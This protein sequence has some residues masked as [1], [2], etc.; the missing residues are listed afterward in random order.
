[1]SRPLPP[2]ADVCLLLEGT[3]P[4]VSGG[5][6]SWVRD[7]IRSLDH[8]SFSIVSIVP[9]GA[10]REPVYDIPANVVGRID[11]PLDRL[12]H[13]RGKIHRARL[14]PT[15]A[16]LEPVLRDFLIAEKS[17]TDSLGQFTQILDKVSR[18]AAGGE[19]DL[20]N[21]PEA[22][23]SLC[24]L[25]QDLAPDASFLDFFWSLRSLTT[26]L[27]A[28]ALAPLPLASVYHT[29]CTGYAGLLG[30]RAVAETERPLVLTEHGI[31]TNE[32]RMEL[33]V[34]DWLYDRPTDSLAIE[35]AGR[36]LRDL[37]TGAFAAYARACYEASSEIITL[38]SGNQDFQRRDGAREERL[39]V[40]PNGIDTERFS[41]LAQAEESRAPTIALIGRV[42]PVKDVKTYIRAVA[43]L[44]QQ[45]PDL[46]ALILGPDREDPDYAKECRTLADQLGLG[47]TVRF[48]GQVQLTDYL[49]HIDLCVLTSLSEAQPLVV[50]EAGAAGVPSVATDVGAC[51]EMILGAPEEQPALGA[52]GAVVPLA[53]PGAAAEAIAALLANPQ[54]RKAAGQA[55]RR[56]VLS[57]YGKDRQTTAYQRLYETLMARVPGP[58]API[59]RELAPVLQ[60]AG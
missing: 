50:L 35:S 28:V 48:E 60:E 44:R 42:V 21:S 29:V 4:Y 52:G 37:W 57:Y 26:G 47:D 10:A 17:G 54:A 39:R 2:P 13:T 49:P 56:R 18:I 15:L 41:T 40:V 53:D 43:R 8:L 9:D 6:S 34:A 12:P 1:M 23:D 16:A 51:R 38:Y 11:L 19:D 14:R 22:W 32:R 58:P 46:T 33:A 30:A 36:S 27:Y 24:T 7:L 31:Y 3:F 5:V 25:Y 59:E 55:M 45:F 20:L